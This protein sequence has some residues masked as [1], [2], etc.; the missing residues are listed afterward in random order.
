MAHSVTRPEAMNA[1]PHHPKVNINVRLSDPF[2]V[3]GSAITGRMELEC[4]ADKCLGLGVIKVELVAIE[5]NNIYSTIYS[6]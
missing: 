2:F 4:R 1:T 5:G 6:A 3:A